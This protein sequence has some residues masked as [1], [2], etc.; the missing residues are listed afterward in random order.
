[1][2]TQT[3]RGAAGRTRANAQSSYIPV[4][5]G[6]QE[7]PPSKTSLA[8]ALFATTR[9]RL[10]GLVF[11]QA[12]RSF[13]ATELIGLTRTGSGAVQRELASH[14]TTVPPIASAVDLIEWE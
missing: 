7:A 6:I 11:G 2:P 8:D 12:G 3:F 9:Q 5:L 1:M 4:Q 10:I 14:Q 13:Y